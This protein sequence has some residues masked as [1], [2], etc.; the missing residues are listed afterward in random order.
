M[1]LGEIALQRIRCARLKLRYPSTQC[2]HLLY[3]VRLYLFHWKHNGGHTEDETEAETD[4]RVK[5]ASPRHRVKNIQ[6]L[7]RHAGVQ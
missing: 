5:S 6:T 7:Q 3:A 2:K 1:Q 4:C